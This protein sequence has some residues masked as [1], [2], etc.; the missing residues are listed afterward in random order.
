MAT[1][2]V[3]QLSMVYIY[4]LKQYWR[5]ITLSLDHV[6][7]PLQFLTNMEKREIYMLKKEK[8]NIFDVVYICSLCRSEQRSTW[9]YMSNPQREEALHAGKCMKRKVIMQQSV[10][11]E[12]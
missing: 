6:A 5:I 4:L 7:K 9:C 11:R 1:R 8:L 2:I 12:N 3:I 10:W